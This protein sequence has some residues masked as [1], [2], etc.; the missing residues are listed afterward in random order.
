MM[1]NISVLLKISLTPKVDDIIKFNSKENNL[2][3]FLVV[4][5]HRTNSLAN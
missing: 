3:N 1:G 4:F 2:K 5:K